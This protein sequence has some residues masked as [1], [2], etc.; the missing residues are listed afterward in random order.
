MNVR[1]A[2]LPYH[3]RETITLDS[4]HSQASIWALSVTISISMTLGDTGQLWFPAR[5]R[6]PCHPRPC[7]R[8]QA[9]RDQPSPLNVTHSSWKPKHSRK[10]WLTNVQMLNRHTSSLTDTQRTCTVSDYCCVPTALPRI[11]ICLSQGTC[12][13]QSSSVF[14]LM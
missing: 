4:T 14:L 8:S 12:S 2:R 13:P 11:P 1:K 3:H 9:L 7:R 10:H 5:S 6:R